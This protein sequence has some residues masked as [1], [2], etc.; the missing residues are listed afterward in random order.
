MHMVSIAAVAS[1]TCTLSLCKH[2]AC[3]CMSPCMSYVRKW[4]CVGAL[5]GG[6]I[7]S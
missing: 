5:P 6:A 7:K 2:Y 4:E 3:V 1:C